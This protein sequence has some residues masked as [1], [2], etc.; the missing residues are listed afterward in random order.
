[1]DLGVGADSSLAPWFINQHGQ[2]AGMSGQGVVFRAES[3]RIEY[4]D[5]RGY[6]AFPGGINDSGQVVGT[7]YLSAPYD[8]LAFTWTPADG[9]VYFG[10]GGS[11][12][13]AAAVNNSGQVAGQSFITDNTAGHA[14]LWTPGGV[15]RDL[16]TLPGGSNSDA[17]AI[18]NIGHVVGWSDV[19]VPPH[20]FVHTTHAFLWS[21]VTQTM[22]DLGSLSGPAGW[23]FATAVNDSGQVVGYSSIPGDDRTHRAF[24]WTE[25]G[26]MR[27]LDTPAG[28]SSAATAIN[29][30]GDIIGWIGGTRAVLW[31]AGGGMVALVMPPLPGFTESSALR[32]SDD[33][34]VLGVSMKPGA[35]RATLWRRQ[36]A[37]PTQLAVSGAGV[38]GDAATLTA[39][40]TAKGTG[41]A[42]K[43]V[44]FS[45]NGNQAGSATTDANGVA[46]LGGIS[47]AGVNA[48][49]YP[50]VVTATFAG[51][52]DYLASSA[53][54]ALIVG[55]ANQTITFDTVAP[56]AAV[57]GTSFPA[58][59][60]A[61][62]GL[63]VVV[64]AAGACS[65]S[66]T[67]ATMHT[68]TGVCSLTADQAGDV[69]YNAAPQV[70]QTTTANYAFKGFLTP[71]ENAPAMNSA[72]A[73][74]AVPLKFS[75]TGDQGLAVLD[76]TPGSMPIACNSAPSAHT[77]EPVAT[78]SNGLSYDASTDQYV[79]IWKTDK[80]WVETCRELRVKLA[81]GTEHR[82]NFNFVK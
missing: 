33:G 58:T 59:A 79:Y 48:G 72:T 57:V 68:P 28:M 4:M 69:N 21:P 78:F 53:Q 17:D 51:A 46:T 80:A 32:L 29:N 39:A 70:R 31:P 65:I 62:S 23:S 71:V 55:K 26:G 45:V 41:V 54:G 67:V 42:G 49:S 63:T 22:H 38:Y 9:P 13:S 40:L 60:T 11:Y 8:A 7:D 34:D 25:A 66:G 81:D 47:V 16:G 56:S 73:G 27:Q 14:F 74:S 36:T 75:L 12:S 77:V 19:P 50:G 1:V 43:T 64:A 52:E 10:L 76:G 82:A 61:S 24:A 5:R 37:S 2:V 6:L 30:R 3:G 15:T 18:S 20:N 44:A 35:W